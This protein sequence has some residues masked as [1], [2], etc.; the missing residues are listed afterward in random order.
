[1]IHAG[2]CTFLSRVLNQPEFFFPLP[3]V[4]VFFLSFARRA[5]R[6]EARSG[7][8]ILH[9]VLESSSS[10][11]KGNCVRIPEK[12]RLGF[13]EIH[14]NPSDILAFLFVVVDEP[15]ALPFPAA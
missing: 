10:H 12:L 4:F 3:R 13:T 2:N 15:A 5:S 1:M 11:R 8:W 6:T 7:F 9:G 14:K